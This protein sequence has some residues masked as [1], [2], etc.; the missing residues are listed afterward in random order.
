[1]TGLTAAAVVNYVL[2]EGKGDGGMVK[3]GMCGAVGLK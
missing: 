1:M 2:V 3:R